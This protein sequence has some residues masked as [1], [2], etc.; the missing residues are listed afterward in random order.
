VESIKEFPAGHWYHSRVGWH[1]YD[2]LEETI[3]LFDGTEDARCRPSSPCCIKRY[4]TP[5]GADAGRR[6]LSGGLDSS[7]VTVLAREETEHLH[8]FAVGV[9]EEVPI[10]RLHGGYQISR[11]DPSRI[12]L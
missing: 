9:E 3:R 12:C 1:K 11:Y 4:T 7:I 2:Q 10:S 5:A 6:D 8:S